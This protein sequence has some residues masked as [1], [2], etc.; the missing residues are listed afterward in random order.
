MGGLFWGLGFGVGVPKIGGGDGWLRRMSEGVIGPLARGFWGFGSD[1]KTLNPKPKVMPSRSG[2]C[3]LRDVGSPGGFM[4]SSQGVRFRV[5]GLGF[6]VQGFGLGS[7][8]RV[9]EVEGF[10][11]TV[12]DPGLCAHVQRTPGKAINQLPSAKIGLDFLALAEA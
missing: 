4:L 5:Q 10:T 11:A 12:R 3:R 6:G 2:W 7:E 9:S 8:F 1:A